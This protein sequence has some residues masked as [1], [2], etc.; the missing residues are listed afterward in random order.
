MRMHGISTAAKGC[1]SVGVELRMMPWRKE[2]NRPD[3]A[4]ESVSLDV[5][6]SRGGI[7]VPVQ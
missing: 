3:T 5:P 6:K 4:T 2:V 7:D 1:A